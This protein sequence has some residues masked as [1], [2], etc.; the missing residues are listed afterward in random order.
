MTQYIYN[1]ISLLTER[2]NKIAD[3]HEVPLEGILF[4]SNDEIIPVAEMDNSNQKVI[5]FYDY[6]CEKNQNDI[7]NYFI[8][9]RQKNCCI[10]YLSQLYNKTSKDIRLN[11][12][13]YIMFAAPSK[14]EALSICK[15]QSIPLDKY[16][17]AFGKN[18]NF[19]YL[20]KMNK[21]LKKNFMAIYYI[22][23]NI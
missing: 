13:H 17:A 8:Q 2:L 1:K 12:S 7:I 14:R 10:I 23:E 22:A 6:V 19:I 3:K 20:D 4:S 21:K 11:C 15:K 9:E 18:Y 5:F 16:K